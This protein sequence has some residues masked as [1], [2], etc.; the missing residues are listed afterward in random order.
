MEN[1][2]LA[3]VLSNNELDDNAK[4]EAIQ[5]M[6]SAKYVSADILANERKKFKETLE[7]QQTNYNNLQTEFNNY[8]QTKMTDEEKAQAIAQQK[9]DDYEKALRKVSKYSAQSVFAEAGLKEEDYSEFLEDIVGLDEEKTKSLAQKIC[10]T[11]TKQKAN[12]EEEIKN[13]ILNGTTPPPAGNNNGNSAETNVEKYQKLLNEAL[14]NNDMSNI[15]YY[16]RLV[17]EAIQNKKF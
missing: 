16:E 2:E 5:K 10:Q 3:N 13:Q 11:I 14:K 9:Q 12:K 1:E 17:Q 7:G 8:K 15:V 6:V 4:I